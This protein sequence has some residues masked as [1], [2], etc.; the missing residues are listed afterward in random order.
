MEIPRNETIK[1]TRITRKSGLPFWDSVNTI[2]FFKLVLIIILIFIVWDLKI[3][4]A[5]KPF[6]IAWTREKFF[7]LDKYTWMVLWELEKYVLLR[8]IEYFQTFWKLTHILE[9]ESRIQSWRHIW[10]PF[11]QPRHNNLRMTTWKWSNLVHAIRIWRR[12]TRNSQ[13]H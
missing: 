12:N 2:I 4:V 8:I 5:M 13:T 9:L 10:Q 7:C 6:S 3:N 1:S 11:P